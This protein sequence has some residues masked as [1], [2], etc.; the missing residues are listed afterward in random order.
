MGPGDICATCGHDPLAGWE[1]KLPRLRKACFSRVMATIRFVVQ[2][3]PKKGGPWHL[4]V[5]DCEHEDWDGART[6]EGVLSQ[7]PKAKVASWEIQD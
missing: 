5:K 4:V 2:H 3:L 1:E 6:L 7:L